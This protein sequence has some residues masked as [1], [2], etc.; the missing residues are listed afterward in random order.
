MSDGLLLRPFRPDDTPTLIA[1]FCDTVHRVNCRDYTPEQVRAWAPNDVDPARW[2]VLS[3]RHTV[4][5][6]VNGVVVGFTDMEPDG[7]I[8]RFF[9]H[10][11]CQGRGVGRA[12]LSEQVA[13]AGRLGILRLYAE[14]SITARPFF[15]RHGF[16]VVAEQEVTVRGTVLINY[17]MER[18]VRPPSS[19]SKA[20]EPPPGSPS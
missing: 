20:E 12:M 13:E 19:I 15:V 11:D 6:E 16:K 3:D 7:H 2:A 10:A 1:L 14:V 9:V 5:T 17:R 8:D 18:L 4:V